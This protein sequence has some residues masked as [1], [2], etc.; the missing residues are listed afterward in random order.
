MW[1]LS[2]SARS[3]QS[4]MVNPARILPPIS[5]RA[6]LLIDREKALKKVK[7]FMR[8]SVAAMLL[9]D[10]IG[11]TFDALVTGAADKGT[12]VR[13]LTPPAEG[14][15]MKGEHGLRVGQKVRGRLIKNRS[16]KRV[17]RF[18]M[19]QQG[20]D[21]INTGILLMERPE[22]DGSENRCPK[23]RKPL[24]NVMLPVFTGT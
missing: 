11:K 12:Y 13:L 20:K 3:K 2:T 1:I 7:R 22:P 17:Y 14:R 23:G 8:K 24:R 18:R 4:L 5:D 9:Q 15:V 16:R 10:S 21:G 19:H 6:L